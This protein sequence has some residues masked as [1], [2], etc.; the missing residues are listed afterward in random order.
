VQ[1]SSGGRELAGIRAGIAEKLAWLG[2][3][4]DPAANATGGPLISRPESRTAIYVIPTDEELMIARQTI[5]LISAR[6]PQQSELA[7]LDC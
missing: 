5:A 6:T 2:G 3:A 4:F 7:H 1:G